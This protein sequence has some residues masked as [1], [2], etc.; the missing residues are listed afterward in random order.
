MLNQWLLNESEL[1]LLRTYGIYG[2]VSSHGRS[3]LTTILPTCY[4][5][6]TTDLPFSSHDE[7][8]SSTS[9]AELLL[10]FCPSAG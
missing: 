1:L 4:P 7:R 2:K 10:F 5:T 9:F 6:T 3:C 8:I